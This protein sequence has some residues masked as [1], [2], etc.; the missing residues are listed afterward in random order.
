MIPLYDYFSVVFQ[1]ARTD[2]ESTTGYMP[3]LKSHLIVPQ[4]ACLIYD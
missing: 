1:N 2:R 3:M 4:A